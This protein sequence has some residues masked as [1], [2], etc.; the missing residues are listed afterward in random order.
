MEIIV[1][2]IVLSMPIINWVIAGRK[3]RNR[4]IWAILGLFGIIPTILLLFMKDLSKQ[5]ENEEIQ[6]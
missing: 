4:L 3:N 2:F 6:K 5:T 1:F